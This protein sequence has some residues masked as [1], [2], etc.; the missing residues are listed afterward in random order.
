MTR[1]VLSISSS[2]EFERE[3]KSI[4]LRVW[5]SGQSTI[6]AAMAIRVLAES[7]DEPAPALSLAQAY[8]ANVIARYR[9]ALHAQRHQSN[10]YVAR[11]QE[12]QRA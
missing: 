3:A 4:A 12:A 10:T 11:Q 1:A 7:L 5:K 2:P 9:D 8:A 6:E